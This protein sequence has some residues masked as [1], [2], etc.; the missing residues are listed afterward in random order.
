MRNK[1][2]LMFM[3]ESDL[4]PVGG[5]SGYLFNIYRFIEGNN[6]IDH[7][8]FL[9]PNNYKLNFKIK[10]NK[11]LNNFIFFKFLRLKSFL[12]KKSLFFYDID[13]SSY[14]V[15]HFHD[16]ISLFRARTMLDDFDGHVILTS[17]SPQPLH[18][19]YVKNNCSEFTSNQT[20]ILSNILELA[21]KFS[22]LRADYLMFPC[23]DAK[24]PYNEWPFFNKIINIQKDKF[25]YCPTG[26][27]DV[28]VKSNRSEIRSKYGVGDKDFL[29]SYVGRHN[30]VK[31]YDILKSIGVK[32][33]K[34]HPNAFFIIAG[35]EEPIKG[36]DHKRWIEIGFT[37]DPHS[38]IN[39]ADLFILPNK[40]TFFDLI[41]LE[42][43]SVGTNLM[44]T[45]TGGNKFF[46]RFENI[47]MQYFDGV[48]DAVNKIN[49]LI[50]EGLEFDKNINRNI[51]KSNF[52]TSNFISSYTELIN[53][54]K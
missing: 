27:E 22:F 15:I 43:F 31:G 51:F 36:L 45:Y 3:S 11:L 5:P 37:N 42:V 40:Q 12:M 35:K 4:K 39:A 41:L 34:Q 23:E 33:L 9:P 20:K 46:K 32:I 1:R 10:F 16:T 17:H 14:D 19:E 13:L 49:S 2:V 48:D 7:I 50:L 38:L 29:I 44:A 52:K 18:I 54:L 53:S 24:D 28:V 26:A 30:S 21:D 47:N 25:L 6:K 8:D